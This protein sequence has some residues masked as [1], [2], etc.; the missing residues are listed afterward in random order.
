MK[1]TPRCHVNV[2][3]VALALLMTVI[4]PVSGAWAQAKNVVSS[5]A[6][7]VA[8]DQP[9]AS[10]LGAE[11][12]SK[13][14]NAADAAVTTLLAL[15]VMNPFASGMG[16]GGFCLYRPN[17]K[18][19]EVLDFRER[20]PSKATRDMYIRDGKADIKLTMVGGLA[21]GVP[22]EVVGLETLHKKYGA[23]AWKDVVGPVRKVAESGFPAGELLP[24][25]L[26]SREERILKHAPAMA[27]IYQKDGTWVQA[28][29][30]VKNQGIAK[31]LKLIET[32]GSAA[33]TTG[34]VPAEISK[35]VQAA[36]G[37]LLA[38]DLGNYQPTWREPLKSTYRGFEIFA[39]PPPSSGGTTILT[40][41]NILEGYDL[42]LLGRNPQTV[43]MVVEALKHAFADRA[44][45]LGDADFV[46]VPVERLISKDYAAQL[47][48]TIKPW[49]TG[50]PSDYGTRANPPDDSGT[51]HVSIV[52][53]DGNMAACTSTINTSFGSM[54]FVEKYGLILN[55]E[56][57]DFTAQP[58]VPNNYGLEGTEQNAVQPGKRPLSSMAPTLVLKDGKPVLAV[59]GSGGP[60]I[61]TGTLL[62][63]IRAL[64]WGMS[65]KDSIETTRIHHQWLPNKL[66]V[67]GDDPA[68]LETFRKRGHDVDVRRAYNSIQMVFVDQNGTRTGVS[69]PRK[70]GAPA[71]STKK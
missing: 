23:L 24:K 7:V 11:T 50:K 13:G 9:Q 54:V 8:A 6:G 49:K 71:A 33:F 37:I 46:D 2:T 18:P 42:P 59:G 25:R 48:R 52:D 16:G 47:R 53:K 70:N 28:G 40:A 44:E 26:K 45:W 38:E 63:L 12:L 35:A 57:G 65:P 39:M 58:G 19:V 21:V 67:E 51:T 61:I 10:K 31:L 41:L 5:K 62:A 20:A 36:G 4:G 34:D 66:F 17:G 60:T 32:K 14:G 3:R 55:N 56:M 27:K 43:H 64:D 29:D 68:Y 30:V 15:G 69:D 22:G 1:S